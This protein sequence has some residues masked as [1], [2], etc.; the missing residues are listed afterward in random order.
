MIYVCILR[1][2]H[3]FRDIQQYYYDLEF[4]SLKKQ[5]VFKR[6]IFGNQFE[7]LKFMEVKI[8]KYIITREKAN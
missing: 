5:F 1:T 4:V 6:N 3:H 2:P 7:A 8:N